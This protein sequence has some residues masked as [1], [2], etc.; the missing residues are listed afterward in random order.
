MNKYVSDA[1]S[2]LEDSM[3]NANKELL[4]SAINGNTENV[5]GL[6]Q[7]IYKFAQIKRM[8]DEDSSQLQSTNPITTYISPSTK[9]IKQKNEAD[10]TTM[11]NSNGNAETVTILTDMTNKRPYSLTMFDET[12]LTNSF[13]AVAETVCRVLYD[14]NQNEFLK[15]ENS[16]NVNGDKHKYFSRKQEPGMT[17]P[18]IIGSGYKSIYID[19][20][21]LAINNLFFLKRVI[22]A[23]NADPNK[24]FVT[25]DPNFR[26]KT[27]EKR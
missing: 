27:R 25:I 19:V 9:T 18:S 2:F 10:N 3:G 16:P 13:R 12:H 21:K 26:R 20:A 6:S 4:E 23:M 8:L 1:K 17:D 24:I 14:K 15:L 5:Q 11:L 7:I 22:T